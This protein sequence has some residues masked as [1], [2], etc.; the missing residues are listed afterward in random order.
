MV[1]RLLADL[2]VLGH[3]GFI[4][5]VVTGGALVIRWPKLAR[6]HLPAVAW[7]VLVEVAGWICPLT[8]LE[9]RLRILAGSPT[10]GDSFIDYYLT[11][12][13]YPQGLTRTIQYGLALSVVMIN[14]AVYGWI[15]LRRRKR[16][17]HAGT[18]R[19]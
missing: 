13:I 12:I 17:G 6:I 10:Y 9:N 2:V 18:N 15:F 4:V 19:P 5:F 11:P 16:P 3:F 8:P 7:A 14:A 1:Y